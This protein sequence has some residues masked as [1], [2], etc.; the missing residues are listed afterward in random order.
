MKCPKCNNTGWAKYGHEIYRCLNGCP[1][2]GQKP[3]G[4]KS[5][6]C[7]KKAVEKATRKIRG[8]INQVRNQFG[9]EG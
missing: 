8:R 7:C 6:E 1:P 3:I 5:R 4:V 2:T 9:I